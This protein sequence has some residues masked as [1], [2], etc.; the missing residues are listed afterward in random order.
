MWLELFS[1]A[2]NDW[3]IASW[4]DVSNG[5]WIK[6]AMKV[7]N[8]IEVGGR[9]GPKAYVAYGMVDRGDAFGAVFSGEAV[10]H[11]AEYGMEPGWCEHGRLCRVCEWEGQAM[12]GKERA[13]P[14]G[15]NLEGIRWK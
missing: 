15:G 3:I 10:A 2:G 4:R 14:R 11:G 6:D 9:A 5:L 12:L 13:Q 1:K 7:Y 8:V